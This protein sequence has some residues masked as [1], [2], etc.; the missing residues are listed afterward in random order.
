MSCWGTSPR[1]TWRRYEIWSTWQ[2]RKQSEIGS[3]PT[4]ITSFLPCYQ[5]HR[6]PGSSH[7][8]S[9]GGY[10]CTCRAYI[11][12]RLYMS[13]STTWSLGPKSNFWSSCWDSHLWSGWGCCTN[14]LSPPTLQVGSTRKR[15]L[16]LT[17]TL[18][19]LPTGN[20]LKRPRAKH[21][22]RV[23][24]GKKSS[25]AARPVRP[26]RLQKTGEDEED[27]NKTVRVTCLQRCP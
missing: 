8:L 12:R 9:D 11:R 27:Q 1:G 5:C 6:E 20:H 3:F 4:I 24:S 14:F 2:C 22:S 10:F 18:L 21:P 17:W 16:I 7:L 13:K 26:K 19:M 15:R 25:R 23:Q